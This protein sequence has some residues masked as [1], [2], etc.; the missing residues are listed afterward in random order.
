MKILPTHFKEEFQSRTALVLGEHC[1]GKIRQT[2]LAIIGVGGVGS[3]AAVSLLRIGFSNM[4]L[5]D[6]DVIEITNFNRHFQGYSEYLG[7]NK[8]EAMVD[9]L[10]KIN[11]WGKYV[12]LFK[13]IDE[14]NFDDIKQYHPDFIIDAIDHLDEK[15]IL[16]QN[17][18]RYNIKV[19]SSMG[20]GGKKYPELVKKGT[21]FSTT[22]CSLARKMRK[23]LKQLN[24][25][26]DLP[27]V[28][29][30][31]PSNFTRQQPGSLF[32]V[33]ASFGLAIA[34]WIVEQLD[35]K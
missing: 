20:A 34:S 8:T 22:D 32:T 24:I 4:L 15:I 3:A 12:G 30:T 31:E 33:T 18:L 35:Q 14:N 6:G 5:A 29:S 21:I 17:C 28:Y 11:P 25:T 27:V 7:W 16:I 26:E 23:I 13:Y 9:Q 19:I 1:L 10:K 2:K